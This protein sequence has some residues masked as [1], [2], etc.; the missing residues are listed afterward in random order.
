MTEEES[1]RYDLAPDS[2]DPGD[3]VLA[4]EL[5]PLVTTDPDTIVPDNVDKE[6]V[7]GA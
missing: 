4:P 5:H 3:T 6:A 1:D 2:N 7:E